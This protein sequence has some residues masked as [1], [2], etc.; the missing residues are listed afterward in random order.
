MRQALRQ[1][2]PARADGHRQGGIGAGEQDH[3]TPPRRL[4]QLTSLG[5]SVGCAEGPEH[6]SRAWG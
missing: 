2:D 6:D 3:P 5:D 1:M 4:R